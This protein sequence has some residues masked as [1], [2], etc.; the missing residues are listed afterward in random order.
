MK[1]RPRKEE[2][3][4]SHTRANINRIR[5]IFSHLKSEHESFR[6][7]YYRLALDITLTEI[8]PNKPFPWGK[9][10]NILRILVCGNAENYDE[11]RLF[12]EK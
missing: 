3:W 7:N 9:F 11:T 10:Q 5:Q 8:E 6:R 2:M 12:D 4:Q 1:S